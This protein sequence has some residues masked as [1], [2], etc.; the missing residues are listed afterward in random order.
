MKR[1]I[2]LLCVL[3]LAAIIVPT[4]VADEEPIVIT[5]YREEL[6]F[7]SIFSL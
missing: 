5:Y 4:A 3:A 1:L 7:R 2:A 6:F